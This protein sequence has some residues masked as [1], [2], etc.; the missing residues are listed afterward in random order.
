M[1]LSTKVNGVLPVTNG[2]T[3][4]SSI[5]PGSLLIGNGAGA[6]DNLVVTDSIMVLTN[7][8]GST[9]LYKVKAG[10]RTF[11]NV[12]TLN[13]TIEIS[14]VDQSNGPNTGSSKVSVPQIVSGSQRIRNF[15]SAGVLPGDIILATTL[16]DLQ[17]ITIS[18]YVR[19]PGQVNVIFFNGTS[20]N[21]A[22]G[23]VNVQFAN[24]GQP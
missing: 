13:K 15:P 2:G 17:G 22:L 11:L 21:V 8:A 9:E 4:Q 20:G 5:S 10:L 23:T 3:G 18:A 16:Q 1:N 24:F 14:A 6:L 19:Q 7:I 12:D